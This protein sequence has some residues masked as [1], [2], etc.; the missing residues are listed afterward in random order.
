LKS[1][2]D[3]GFKVA[4]VTNQNGIQKGKVKKGDFV[5]KIYDIC[6]ELGFPLQVF[7]CTG[8]D[9]FRKPGTD[10]FRFLIGDFNNNVEPDL[11]VSFYCGDAAGRPEGVSRSKKKIILVL[12]ENLLRIII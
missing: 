8:N 12:I 4:I 9:N 2:K 5:G 6:L 7:A 11:S 3:S 1:L 10:I